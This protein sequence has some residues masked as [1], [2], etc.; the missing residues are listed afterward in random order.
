[1]LI[2]M[3]MDDDDDDDCWLDGVDDLIFVLFKLC[4]MINL[5]LHSS[6]H[7]KSMLCTEN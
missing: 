4:I 7:I 5:Y 6:T 3:S 1:M 2:L